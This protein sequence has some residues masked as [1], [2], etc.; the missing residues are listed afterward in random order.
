MFFDRFSF[1]PR[2]T[3]AAVLLLAS[4]ALALFA[5]PAANGP[6][7]TIEPLPPLRIEIRQVGLQKQARGGIVSLVIDL[8]ADAAIEDPVVTLRLPDGVILSD[9]SRRRTWRPRLKRGRKLG[10]RAALI[11]GRDGAHPIS[12]EV[13]GTLNGQP[14]RRGVSHDLRIGTA[15]RSLPRRHGAIEFPGVAG[16]DP[17]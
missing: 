13:T 11:A 9:G 6:L 15:A 16:G 8:L 10:L 4:I 17:Q 7:R 1:S 5:G 14:V 12:I 2:A 3:A